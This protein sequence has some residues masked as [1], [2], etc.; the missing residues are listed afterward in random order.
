M[1]IWCSLTMNLKP[2]P[3]WYTCER[4]WFLCKPYY[5]LTFTQFVEQFNRITQS[6]VNNRIC[7]YNQ[8]DCN[9]KTKFKYSTHSKHKNKCSLNPLAW[10]IS[11]LS[12][13][14]SST[15]CCSV[16]TLLQ[17]IPQRALDESEANER[18]KIGFMIHCKFLSPSA[19]L[20]ITSRLKC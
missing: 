3:I 1:V 19:S 12:L 20:Q 13:T 15:C 4:F 14:K 8:S 5:R 17:K 7:V 6:I 10:I 2:W 18:T 9:W 16:S 11:I